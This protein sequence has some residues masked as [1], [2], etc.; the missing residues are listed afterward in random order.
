ME[1]EF[2]AQVLQ[3]ANAAA[4]PEAASPTTRLALAALRDCGVLAAADAAALIRADGI[5]RTV[6][7]MLRLTDGRTQADVL[8]A[9]TAEAL[10]RAAAA[11]G[12]PAVDV[13][14]LRA[15]SDQLARDVRAAFV[16]LVGDI[17]P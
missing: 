3:L 6:Q 7:G 14:A 12:A 9:T 4:H 8:P 1:V 13:D 16:R 2:I 5:W 10:L 15:T 17:E 11:A